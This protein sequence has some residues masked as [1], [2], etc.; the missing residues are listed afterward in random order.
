M[1][2]PAPTLAEIEKAAWMLRFAWDELL[3]GGEVPDDTR[4]RLS[5]ACSFSAA[6]HAALRGPAGAVASV[7]AFLEALHDP[8]SAS[9]DWLRGT[10]GTGVARDGATP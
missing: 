9:L 3:S 7:T 8:S 4:L 5:V 6:A 10:P 1:S 2:T